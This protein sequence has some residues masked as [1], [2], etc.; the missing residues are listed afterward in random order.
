VKE[1]SGDNAFDHALAL[2]TMR[3]APASLNA[4]LGETACW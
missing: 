3:S 2:E 4:A 1:N